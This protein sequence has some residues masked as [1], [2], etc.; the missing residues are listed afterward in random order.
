MNQQQMHKLNQQISRRMADEIEGKIRRWIELEGDDKMKALLA[1][2]QI[3][4]QQSAEAHKIGD[5]LIR[6]IQ[7]IA[8][9]GK[10]EFSM[11]E[12]LKKLLTVARRVFPEFKPQKIITS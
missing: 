2:I 7:E 4:E 6:A 5:Q 3:K 11:S 9:S 12:E 1:T 8:D 10:L